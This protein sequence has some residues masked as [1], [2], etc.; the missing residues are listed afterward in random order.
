MEFRNRKEF[1][2]HGPNTNFGYFK[3]RDFRIKSDSPFSNEDVIN[4]Y[5]KSRYF[6]WQ[7]TIHKDDNWNFHGIHNAAQIAVSDFMP[8]AF[9]RLR[10]ELLEFINSKCGN[11]IVRESEPFSVDAKQ[12]VKQLM[13]KPSSFARHLSENIQGKEVDYSGEIKLFIE[14]TK[15]IMDDYSDAGIFLKLALSEKDKR[16]RFTVYS[17]FYS[18]IMSSTDTNTFV[19]I[20][21]GLD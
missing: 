7:N 16:H 2:L 3:L 18:A 4:Y 13:N 9:E 21:F 14:S 11:G 20:E 5:I 6:R 8:Q 1:I 10:Q 12:F 19:T 17:Y 15:K